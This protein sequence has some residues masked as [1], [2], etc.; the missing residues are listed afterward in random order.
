MSRVGDS[1]YEVQYSVKTPTTTPA[2][3]PMATQPTSFHDSGEAKRRTQM[4]MVKPMT[5]APAMAMDSRRRCRRSSSVVEASNLRERM[6]RMP[7]RDETTPAPAIQKGSATALRWSLGA[8]PIASDGNSEAARVAVA[9]MEP[10]KDS[11]RSAPMPATSPTLSPTLSAITAGLR[12]SSSGMRASVLPTR[13][14]P[15]SA[16]LVNTPPATRAKRA[17]EDAPKPKP[18]M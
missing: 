16:A 9:M 1:S 5:A 7:K 15:T 11:N 10:T 18:D 13:S 6:Y 2:T 4:R 12:G 14:A 3:R 17:M 8:F